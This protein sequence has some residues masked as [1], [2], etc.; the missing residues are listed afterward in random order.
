MPLRYGH[1]YEFRVRLAD[2]TGG[3]FPERARVAGRRA[4]TD[5]EHH[6]VAPVEFRRRKP[7]GTVEIEQSPTRADPLNRSRAAA[8]A[9]GDPLHR[10]A[11]TF[12]ELEDELEPATGSVCPTPT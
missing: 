2:L 5:P 11:P 9:P 7:T 8:R 4:D 10:D 1:Q 3:G 12:A 6:H